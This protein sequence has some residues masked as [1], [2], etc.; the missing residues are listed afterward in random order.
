MITN[1]AK[2][3]MGFK[4]L[5]EGATITA[6]FHALHVL[7]IRGITLDSATSAHAEGV[8]HGVPYSIAIGPSVNLTTRQLMDEDFTDDEPTWTKEHSCSPPYAVI[9]FG[10]TEPHTCATGYAQERDEAILTYD[11][12][13]VAREELRAA[14]E[15]ALPSLTAALACTYSSSGHEI[16]VSNVDSAVFGLTETGKSIHDV[17]LRMSA[18]AFASTRL[19]PKALANGVAQTTVLA[20][21]MNSKVARFYSLALEERDL[22][23]RFLYFFLSIEV[24]THA[25]FAAIDH[26][27]AFESLVIADDRTRDVVLP[28]LNE[29]RAQWRTLKER[30]VWCVV[31]RWTH[32]SRK[33]VEDFIRLKRVRDSIAHGELASPSSV[34]VVSVARLATLLHHSLDQRDA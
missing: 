23:K 13:A 31:C 32:L 24:Q 14:A 6:R 21:S 3:I 16:Q 22:L 7:A 18:T 27:G 8:A 34:D 17:C 25:A 15:K 2:E 12:F 5:L 9:H 19:D 10:P 11:A 26:P 29:Q 33:D 4:A 20:A 30:F 1:A 28:F